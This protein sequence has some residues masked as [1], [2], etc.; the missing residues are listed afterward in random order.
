MNIG[1]DIDGVIFDTERYYRAYSDFFNYTRNGGRDIVDTNEP[2]VQ[3]RF[4]WSDELIEEFMSKYLLSIQEIAPILPMAREVLEILRTRG[5][6]LIVISSRGIHYSKEIDILMRRLDEYGLKFDAIHLSLEDKLPTC[7][8][9]KIDVILED[10]Y[11]NVCHLSEN[12]VPCLYF[13]GDIL[14]FCK[15]ANVIEV[16]NWGQVLRALE[17]FEGVGFDKNKK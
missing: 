9:E 6:R 5:H 8:E 2:R 4:A 10:Y 7:R 15:N 16:D 17:N 3:K 11:D 1:I 13:R 12:G 14:K